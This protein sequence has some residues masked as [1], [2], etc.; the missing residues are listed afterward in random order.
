MQTITIAI[1]FISILK[2]NCKYFMLSSADFYLMFLLGV[3]K[4]H[5]FYQ[6]SMP[7]TYSLPGKSDVHNLKSLC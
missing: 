4:V 6:T 1:P 2:F 7:K 3:L 5:D